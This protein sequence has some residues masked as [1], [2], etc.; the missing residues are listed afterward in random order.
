MTIGHD[1]VEGIF[2]GLGFLI[3]P[4]FATI[5]TYT[6]IKVRDWSARRRAKAA[7]PPKAIVVKGAPFDQA[8]PRMRQLQ[9]EA[10]GGPARDPELPAR[11]AF[12]KTPEGRAKA[13]D[14]VR[15]KIKR[16]N[17]K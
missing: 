10:L 2:V 12:S 16:K 8:T 14:V 4:V 13:A 11:L 6:F 7:G 17:S 15:G 1:I 5:A 9:A 3:V